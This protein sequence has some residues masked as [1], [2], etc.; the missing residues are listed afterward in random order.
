MKNKRE[1]KSLTLKKVTVSDLN[2]RE[3]ETV[4]GGQASYVDSKCCTF[5]CPTT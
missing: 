4:R 2:S 5:D 3:M 1:K